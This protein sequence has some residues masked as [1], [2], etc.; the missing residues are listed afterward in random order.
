[1]A[2]RQGDLHFDE[3][4]KVR[5]MSGDL[6]AR[7]QEMKDECKEFVDKMGTFQNL[8]GGF[9]GTV[10][11]LSNAVE[12][13]KLKAI[14]SR[15]LLKSIEKQRQSDQQQLQALITEKKLQLERYRIEYESLLKCEAEQKEFIEQFMLQS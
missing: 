14:G 4:S 7:T 15:N 1:M 9:I 12:A 5:L 2:D 13:E 6:S 8:A 10:D 3:L 11:K